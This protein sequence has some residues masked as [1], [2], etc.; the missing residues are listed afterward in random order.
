MRGKRNSIGQAA[1]AE[2]RRRRRR[3][4]ERWVIALAD[5]DA[6]T[7]LSTDRA[8]GRR[9]VGKG[10]R[11]DEEEEASRRERKGCSHSPSPHSF[12]LPSCEKGKEE[13]FGLLFRASDDDNRSKRRRFEEEGDYFF[14]VLLHPS[15]CVSLL[16]SL[17]PRPP[18]SA[19]FVF[20]LLLFLLLLFLLLLLLLLLRVSVFTCT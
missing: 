11:R 3:Y 13:G 19:Y 18:S 10:G 7:F 12:L 4:S 16:P 20:L 15:I 9:K 1:A 5:M 14:F 6:H 8:C 17:S 2:E